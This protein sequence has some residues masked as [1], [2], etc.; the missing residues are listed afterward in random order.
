[1]SDRATKIGIPGVQ[2]ESTMAASK[3]KTWMMERGPQLVL[4]F[5]Q[6]L[7]RFVFL[8]QGFVRGQNVRSMELQSESMF[9]GRKNMLLLFSVVR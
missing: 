1:M 5:L 7:E 8:F 4:L 9:P 2:A 3:R 6:I